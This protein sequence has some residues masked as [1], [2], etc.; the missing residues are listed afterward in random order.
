MAAVPAILTDQEKELLAILSASADGK[1]R[2]LEGD[3][4][5]DEED[6]SSSSSSSSEGSADA[7]GG[8][9]DHSR[10]RRGTELDGRGSG[11][12]KKSQDI[13]ATLPHE[14]ELPSGGVGGGDGAV[15][16]PE[17]QDDCVSD[18]GRHGDDDEDGALVASSKSLT[19]NS[20]KSVVCTTTPVSTQSL[21]SQ[22][23]SAAAT[24]DGAAVITAED[25][26]LLQEKLRTSLR[27]ETLLL[28]LQQQLLVQLENLE[29]SIIKSESEERM[30]RLAFQ[31]AEVT[32]LLKNVQEAD[33]ESFSIN[34]PL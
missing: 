21:T 18:D 5:E 27:E 1:L 6:E 8:S 12:Q 15:D 25:Y 30:A 11:L 23:S 10:Y 13:V 17:K 4:E 31:Q 24:S 22:S 2:R 33:S 14:D 29:Q 26:K 20:S 19:S 32:R 28:S 16:V 9:L 7:E 3:E 34:A